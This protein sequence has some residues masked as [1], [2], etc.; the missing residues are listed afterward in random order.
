VDPEAAELG[1]ALALDRARIVMDGTDVTLLCYGADGPD[2]WSRP[3]RPGRRRSVEVIDLRLAVPLDLQTI[4]DSV[5]RTGRCVWPTRRRSPRPGRGIATRITEECFYQLESPVLRVGVS[6]PP[7]PP[8]RLEDHTWPDLER[9]LT[10]STA[11]RRLR[12]G[13]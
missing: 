6:P 4:Y 1:D 13:W 7:Y 9:V 3:C 12:G 5:R 11:P 10:P 2:L 8:S